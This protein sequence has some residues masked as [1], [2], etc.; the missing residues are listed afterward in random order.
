VSATGGREDT[1]ITTAEIVT[2]IETGTAREIG[3]GIG[4]EI[5]IEEGMIETIVTAIEIEIGTGIGIGIGAD[6]MMPRLDVALLHLIDIVNLR[7]H[8]ET[9]TGVRQKDHR[10]Q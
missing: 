6:T 1:T 8:F 3:T 9:P 5:E 4:I 7:I 10:L 2:G